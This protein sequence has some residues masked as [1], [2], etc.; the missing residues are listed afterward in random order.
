M[1]IKK[2]PKEVPHS[3]RVKVCLDLVKRQ[4]INGKVVVDI[5]CSFGWL[6][7]EIVKL[8]PKKII[9]VEMDKEAVDF[10]KR[11]VKGVQFL[12]GSALE[13]PLPN[14]F[15][16]IICFFDVIEH[17]PK[18]KERTSL[19]EINRI[20]KKGGILLL[21][22][23]NK[24]LFS[25]ILDI[26]W[27]FG[28]RH[29]SKKEVKDLLENSRFKIENIMIRGSI[30]SSLYLTWFYITKRLLNNSQPKNSFFERLDDLGYKQDGITDIFLVARK[31]F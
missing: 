6:E 30:L 17:V 22:T 16:D 21:S 4:K 19:K 13:L 28:H 2:F 15:A 25:N 11:N 1:N 24:N 9:G 10:A 27:Y 31:I 23:P 29:Y 14:N 8:T 5:G 3:G 18:T 20:L 7:K 12:E 26:A